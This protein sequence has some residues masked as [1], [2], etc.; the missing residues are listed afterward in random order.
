[1][2]LVLSLGNRFDPAQFADLPGGPLIVKYAPQLELLKV[3]RLVIAHGGANTI[4]ETL[5]AGKPMLLIPLAYDQPAMAARLARLG[6]AEVLPV[7]RLSSKRI[8]TAIT[9]LLSDDRYHDAAMDMRSRVSLLRGVERSADVI[10]ESLVRYQAGRPKEAP[11]ESSNSN[12][13]PGLTGAKVAS[14]LQS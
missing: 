4:F 6:I 12:R 8:R 1:V 2:Q 14:F 5:M 11:V 7:K 3:T 10:E 9:K 13:T